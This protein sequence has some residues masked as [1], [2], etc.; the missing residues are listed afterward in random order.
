MS[1]GESKR[2]TG[3][4]T[5]FSNFELPLFYRELLESANRKRTYVLRVITALIVV[6]VFGTFYIEMT[7]Y[8]RSPVQFMGKG[9]DLAVAIFVTDLLAIFILLPA[10]ACTAISLERE[11]QTLSLLLTSL[12]TPGQIVMEKLLSRIMPII[13][14]LIAS[15]P[16]LGITYVCGGFGVEQAV[17]MIV[18]LLVAAI[19]VSSTAIFCS[20]FSRTAL[21]A[22]W[23]TYVLL[24]AM[25]LLPLLMNEL[26]LIPQLQFT[27]LIVGDSDIDNSQLGFAFCL[28]L[29]SVSDFMYQSVNF[30]ALFLACMPPLVM[31][32]V[33]LILGRL[34]L[35]RIG[36][37]EGFN[38]RRSGRALS[39]KFRDLLKMLM[40]ILF[41]QTSG[42]ERSAN[43]DVPGLQTQSV[44]A[45]HERCPVPEFGSIGWRER[46]S[47]AISGWKLYV[48]LAGLIVFAEFWMFVALRAR[49]GEFS[50]T[51]V[52]VVTEVIWS[53][54][55]LLL[56]MSLGCRVFP[57]EKERQTLD[58]IL[59]IPISNRELLRQKCKGV[60]M[61]I[62]FILGTELVA[63]GI[64]L[65]IARFNVPPISLFG[66][67]ANPSPGNY[68][69][70]QPAVFLSLNWILA[71]IPYLWG[72]LITLWVYLEL[73]KWIS[74]GMGLWLKSQMKAMVASILTVL[75]ICFVPML[76]MVLFMV[77]T[78]NNPTT[79]PI[80]CF[81]SPIFIY[82]FNLADEMGNV[83]RSSSWPDSPTV[84]LLFNLFIYGGFTLGVRLF[85]VSQFSQFIERRD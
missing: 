49:A 52:A 56:V 84:T 12:L 13:V 44:R 51:E 36:T 48:L 73:C 57:G 22:F 67:L 26:G 1:G 58:S 25:F 40:S 4:I 28:Y 3:L 78:D 9:I 82:G 34:I 19:Q 65:M 20:S 21:G 29:L 75:V 8:S 60:N 47:S 32:S 74:I 10:M 23:A 16:V 63:M 35:I 72:T 38:L 76:T 24:A 27:P 18:V 39:A 31:S 68:Y 33:L 66:G 80:F 6:I 5:F 69:Q 50:G 62:L 7:W 71:V 53:I 59:V 77:L 46:Q 2:P 79:M 11:K 30:T 41:G 14:L 55:A 45:R 70:Y 85:V 83:F 43:T 15:A 54:I 61:A 42:R 81:S 64:H 37:G 17:L